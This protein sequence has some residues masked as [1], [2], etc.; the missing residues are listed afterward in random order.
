MRVTIVLLMTLLVSSCVH[1]SSCIL[2]PGAEI[3]KEK[4]NPKATVNCSF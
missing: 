4:V 2:D 1:Q 3:S